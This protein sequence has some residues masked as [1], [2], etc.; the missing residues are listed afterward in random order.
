MDYFLLDAQTGELRTGK[1]LDKEA[2]PDATGLIT[3]TVKAHEILDDQQL[4][5]DDQTSAT[6]QVSIT[7][8]DVNDSPPQFNQREYFATL[9]ENTPIGT[10]HPIIFP[11]PIAPLRRLLVRRSNPPSPITLTKC[12]RSPSPVTLTKH[13][14]SKAFCGAQGHQTRGLVAEV[15]GVEGARERQRHCPH[16]TSVSDQPEAVGERKKGKQ[17]EAQ[18]EANE[19][20]E[21]Q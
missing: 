19:G 6:T 5:N 10:P 14:R 7:I 9:N 15:T 2:L 8:R 17:H 16:R 1:P 3:L 4:G 21:A 20:D 11:Q 12:G 13:G 18:R